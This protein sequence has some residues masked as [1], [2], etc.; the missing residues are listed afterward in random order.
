MAAGTF[1]VNCT[2]AGTK[3]AVTVA[4][5]F[6]VAEQGPLPAHAPLQLE[7]VNPAFGIAFGD[8]ITPAL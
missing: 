8:A 7:N 4:G 5:A 3:F 1:T 2:T 6:N